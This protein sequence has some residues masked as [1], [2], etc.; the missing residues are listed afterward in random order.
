MRPKH[1]SF[2]RTF[3]LAIIASAFAGCGDE[4][5]LHA[6]PSRDPVLP[7]E[8]VRPPLDSGDIRI[9]LQDQRDLDPVVLYDACDIWSETGF[10]CVLEPDKDRAGIR[11]YANEGPCG[12]PDGDGKVILGAAYGGG[13]IVIETGCI[14]RSWGGEPDE[15]A[16]RVLLA[17][18]IGH[19]IGLPHVN[20][21][22]YAADLPRH[23]SGPAICGAAVMNPAINPAVDYMTGG[24]WLNFE[25]YATYPGPSLAE[26]GDQPTCTI[27]GSPPAP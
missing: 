5:T 3:S 12:D 19:I 21:D 8:P 14:G 15:R 23:W 13:N 22:C 17:H 1:L 11:I 27:L 10:S 4:A 26:S 24:D 16:M 20:P 9:W 6:P 18:E 2:W 7:S 25:T